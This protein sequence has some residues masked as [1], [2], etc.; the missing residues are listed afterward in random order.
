MEDVFA[1]FASEADEDQ[2]LDRASF[3]RCFYLFVNEDH[4]HDDAER[5]RL[6]LSRL[7]DL[8]DVE[9]RGL[10]HLSHL[11]SGLSTLCGGSRED[12]YRAAF[13]LYGI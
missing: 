8:F 11:L 4:S 1:V 9:G 2:Q 13:A 3:N 10:V 7:F 12:K 5:H 6:V